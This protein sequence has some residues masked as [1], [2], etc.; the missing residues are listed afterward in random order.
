M[1]RGLAALGHRVRIVCAS[2]N[3]LGCSNRKASAAEGARHLRIWECP[4]V[5]PTHAWDGQLVPTQD[6]INFLLE[7][8]RR[9]LK[10]D[11]LHAHDWHGLVAACAVGAARTVP[12]VFTHHS[13]PTEYYPGLPAEKPKEAFL[14]KMANV[15]LVTPIVVPSR[16][17]RDELLKRG[18]REDDVV[19]I[20]WGMS[21]QFHQSKANQPGLATRLRSRKPLVFCPT[22]HDPPHKD[23]ET[24][25]NAAHEVLQGWHAGTPPTFLIATNRTTKTGAL[26]WEKIAAMGMAGSFIVETLT[27]DEM[28]T[29]YREADVTVIPSRRES[30]GMV[31]LEAFIYRTPV[32]AAAS[33]A[34]PEVV[35]HDVTGLLFTDG[36][37]E[38]LADRIV[39]LLTDPTHSKGLAARALAAV[40]GEFT[41]ER[42]ARA[43]SQ[44]YQRL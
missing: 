38:E 13:A 5:P 21:A 37:Y 26:L 43:H 28:P 30:F 9:K 40:K 25:V 33:G 10:G 20:P 11:V 36:A 3:Q 34:I 4:E 12:V 23:V 27:R 17:S 16:V 41:R 7:E 15:R 22:R 32:I 39:R 35:Q 18:F 19:T 2:T 24:F 42:M 31:I 29:A 44:L 14:R 8:W 1:S 6:L